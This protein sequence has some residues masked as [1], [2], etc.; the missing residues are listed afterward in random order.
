MKYNFSSQ[1]HTL[2]HWQSGGLVLKGR[3]PYLADP[4]WVNFGAIDKDGGFCLYPYSYMEADAQPI[5]YNGNS[6]YNIAVTPGALT[7]TGRIYK[8]NNG[9]CAIG[10]VEAPST[11]L[12]PLTAKTN[13]FSATLT[14]IE[15]EHRNSRLYLPEGYTETS[16]DF[17][18]FAYSNALKATCISPKIHRYFVSVC[19]KVTKEELPSIY[20][21]FP[22]YSINISGRVRLS[23]DSKDW[24]VNGRSDA[25]SISRVV[26]PMLQNWKPN[27]LREQPDLEAKGLTPFFLYDY[28]GASGNNI[29]VHGYGIYE[30]NTGINAGYKR[31][32]K[33]NPVRPISYCCFGRSAIGTLDGN[34]YYYSS[35]TSDFTSRVQGA[36]QC[37]ICDGLLFFPWSASVPGTIYQKDETGNWTTIYRRCYDIDLVKDFAFYDTN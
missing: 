11:Q 36:Q 15:M 2:T 7:V 9:Y 18:Y 8:W 27:Q 31:N 30:T 24:T 21:D 28:G 32:V 5:D 34:A 29:P 13:P 10:I 4:D 16:G 1:T 14:Y 23:G 17:K 19:S 37:L 3:T 22:E 12:I 25:T 20:K 35:E 26:T 6:I 33:A